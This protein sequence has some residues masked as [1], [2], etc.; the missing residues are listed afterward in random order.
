[1]RMHLCKKMTVFSGASVRRALA[2]VHCHCLAFTSVLLALFLLSCTK[3]ETQ[4]RVPV[5]LGV[6]SVKSKA[7]ALESLQMLEGRNF[8]LLAAGDF[9]KPDPMLYNGNAELVGNGVSWRVSFPGDELLY[10]PVLSDNNY[11]FYACS[12]GA[13]DVNYSFYRRDGSMKIHVPNDIYGKHDILWA[14]SEATPLYGDVEGFNAQYIRLL[15]ENAMYGY[16]PN[17]EFTHVASAIRF[18]LSVEDQAM[19]DRGFMVIRTAIRNVS[20]AA[21]LDMFTGVLEDNDKV[22]SMEYLNQAF[23]PTLE[24]KLMKDDTFYIAPGEYPQLAFQFQCKAYPGAPS[25]YP[26]SII[27]IDAQQILEFLNKE[28]ITLER[29]KRYTFEVVFKRGSFGYTAVLKPH[30]D[31]SE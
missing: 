21:T 23:N 27:T 28:T 17:L 18:K 10:Y 15:Q 11:S 24:G 8:G 13:Q 25:P 5:Q 30:S 22:Y 1:M 29:G 3:E 2:Q 26:D 20:N 12:F 7:G 14:R 6:G 31:Q 16:L 19:E 9:N 4:D